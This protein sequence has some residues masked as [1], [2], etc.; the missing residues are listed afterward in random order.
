LKNYRIARLTSQNEVKHVG[1]NYSNS[2]LPK[3]RV[4]DFMF[5]VVCFG[6]LFDLYSEWSQ[7][8]CLKHPAGTGEKL[9]H[10]RAR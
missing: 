1:D 10:D 6:R 3:P 8:E 7:P 9:I 5:H 4:P 2:A